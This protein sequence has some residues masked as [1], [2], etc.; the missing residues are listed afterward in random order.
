[1]VSRKDEGE[2]LQMA[3]CSRTSKKYFPCKEKRNRGGS[4]RKTWGP[5]KVF[6]DRRKNNIPVF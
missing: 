5:K 4:Q 6:K 1:M 3:K 2:K